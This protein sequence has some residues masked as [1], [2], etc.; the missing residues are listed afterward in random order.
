MRIGILG[1]GDVG[2]AL[3]HGFLE[4]GHEVLMGAREAQN[5]K[6]REWARQAGKLARAGSF[7]DAAAFGEIVVLAT[8]GTA[9]VDAIGMAG[10]Q[11]FAG[12]LVLD[13]TNPLDHSHGMPPTLAITGHDSG[14]ETIQRAIPTAK[15]VK[16]WNTVGNALMFRP[17]LPGGPPTMFICGNDAAAKQTATG[18]LQQ[19]G[20][21][22]LDAGDIRSSRYL[23]AMCLTWVLTAANGN[24]WMQAFKMLRA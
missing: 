16:A 1:T 24:H 5:P 21:E 6:A 10:P 15:V 20:W 19:W 4:T 7:A 3:G 9:A 2:K 23:E 22:V 14:G 17:Q 13:A 11:H 12:K 18:I 8:M